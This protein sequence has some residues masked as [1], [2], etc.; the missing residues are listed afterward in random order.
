MQQFV[1]RENT[2]YNDKIYIMGILNVTPDSFS[3]GG[4][5]FSLENAVR[6]ALTMQE[7]GADFIDVGAVSTRPG[8]SFVTEEEEVQRLLPVL[9]ALQGKLQI[10]VSVDTFRPRVAELALQAGAAVI[11]HVGDYSESMARV[12]CKYHAGWIAVHTVGD[13]ANA[14]NYPQGVVAAVQD[15][16]DDYHNKATACGVMPQ[17]LIFDPGFGFA[18]NTAQ[19]KELLDNLENLNT[20]NSFLMTAL[21]R[22][23]FVGELTNVSNPADR[24]QGTLLYDRIAIEKGSCIL[25][26][27]DVKAHKEMTERIFNYG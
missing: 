13:A 16:I 24:L 6:Q 1:C 14:V 17:Q 15:F 27:H 18:K 12:I 23:R 9:Q 11:N 25:R 3:D 5:F 10:P 8:A 2:Y 19:N 20:H 4:R 26:V 7:E 21:S 22:K